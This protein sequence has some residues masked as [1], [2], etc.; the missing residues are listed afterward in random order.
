MKL[1]K[2]MMQVVLATF[3]FGLLGTSTVFDLQMILKDGSLSKKM[4]EPT[5][6]R[7]I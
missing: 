4:V 3:F 1:L 7:G 6:K 5:T 2:K